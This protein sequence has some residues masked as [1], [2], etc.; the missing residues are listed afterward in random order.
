MSLPMS[1]QLASLLNGPSELLHYLERSHGVTTKLVQFLAHVNALI[2]SHT[3]I[4]ADML[5][6]LELELYLDFPCLSTPATKDSIIIQHALN[7]FYYATIVYFRRTLRRVPLYDVQ[8]LVEKAVQELEAADALTNDRGGC[9][10]N[11]ACFVAAA[12]CERRDLQTR[13]L[14]YFDRKSRHGIQNISVLCEIVLALWHRRAK[15]PPETDIQW[16]EIAK[17][18][19]FDIMLV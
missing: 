1:S 17:E 6:R 12:E 7:A 10:Y 2:D 13:M 3:A 14:A 11:W 16:Q 4:N 19:D 5:D 8:E 15:A 18:A 9:A